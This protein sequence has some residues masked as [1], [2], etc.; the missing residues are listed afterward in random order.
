MQISVSEESRGF[1]R[2]YPSGMP[3]LFAELIGLFLQMMDNLGGTT[4]KGQRNQDDKCQCGQNPGQNKNPW[5]PA[6]VNC[7][8]KHEQ[9]SKAHLSSSKPELVY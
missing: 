6:P 5:Q 9:I 3:Q 1:R 8:K 7:P 4:Y 2:A